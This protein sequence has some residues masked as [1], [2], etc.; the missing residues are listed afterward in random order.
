MIKQGKL[1]KIRLGNL[2]AKRDWG[3]AKDYV[4]AMWLMLQQDHPE[5][6]V[7]ATGET[8]TVREFVEKSFKY[9]DVDITWVGSGVDEKELIPKP[10][11]SWYQLI[12]IIS[13]QQKLIY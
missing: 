7:I 4:E 1:S 10:K 5:D 12:R 2:D 9:I 13:G 11:R 3:Y 6:F 8:H